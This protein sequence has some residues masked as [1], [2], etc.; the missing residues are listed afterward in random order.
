MRYNVRL[1]EDDCVCESIFETSN[2]NEALKIV[3]QKNVFNGKKYI[4]L[5]CPNG[6]FTSIKK[7]KNLKD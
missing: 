4:I 6:A 3:E 5:S 2:L 7:Q 1:L